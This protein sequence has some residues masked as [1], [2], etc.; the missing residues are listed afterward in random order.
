ME[1]NKWLLTTIT[2]LQ[3]IDPEKLGIEGLGGHIN[4][5]EREILCVDDGW[6]AGMGVSAGGVQE[7]RWDKGKEFS[8]RWLRFMG[9]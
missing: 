3:P 8:D 1:T 4:L 5:P 6:E 7:N 2:N 9:I